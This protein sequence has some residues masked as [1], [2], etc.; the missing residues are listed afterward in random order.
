MVEC[1]YKVIASLIPPV[2]VLIDTWWNVNI[3]F[4]EHYIDEKLVLID[5]WWN[6]NNDNAEVKALFR[7]F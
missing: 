1:E 4:T 5:T 6:V 3:K 7:E 2:L